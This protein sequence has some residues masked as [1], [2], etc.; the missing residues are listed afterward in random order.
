MNLLPLPRSV[1]LEGP[2][3]AATEPT[4]TIRTGLPPQ[5]YRLDIGAD[6]VRVAAA[7]DAGAFYARATL[8]QLR[9]EFGAQL[10][11]GAIE[12]WPDLPVRG[13]ML[14]IS[15][16]KV[17]TLETL[18]TLI[19]RL[20]SWK[21]NHVELYSEHTFAY[22]DHGIVWRDASPLTPEEIRELDA[23]CAARYVEL[24]PNQNT[25]G[26]FERWLRHEEYRHLALA[27]DGF[28]DAF[29]R[30]RGPTTID[31]TNPGSLDLVRALLAEL[32]PNFTARRV[33]V[34]LD[35]PWELPE[36]R[37]D[38]Y[39]AWVAQLRA[40]P[41]LD[42]YELLVWSDILAGRPERLAAVPPGVT[43]CEWGYE[44]D[45]DFDARGA[46]YAAAGVPFW[47]SPGTSSWITILGRWTNMVATTRHAIAAA[48]AHGGGGMLT[49]DWGDQGHLQHLPI[50]EPGLAYAAAVSWGYDRNADVDLAATVSSVVYADPTGELGV[51]LQELGD[52]HLAITPQ[53]PNI[54]TLVMHLYYPQIPLGHSF[55]RGVT[56]AELDDVAGRLAVVRGRL[57]R[58]TPARSDSELVLRELENAVDLVALLVRDAQLRLGGDGSLA[59]IPE[60]ARLEL[61]ADLRVVTDEHRDL[62]LTRHR[63]GGLADSHAWLENLRLAYEQG[64]ADPSWSGPRWLN[65]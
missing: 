32:L 9:A 1:A 30:R 45:S 31:P 37:V 25:L 48:L 26:H 52:L 61:A 28:T 27:P 21:I 58:A 18:L 65:G 5:G 60:A 2:F 13:V 53:F 23:F 34:G 56:T 57:A 38:D 33:H 11:S 3:V 63:P 6:G 51:A 42:G 16:D 62:W 24:V 40:L 44:A 20:A 43:I 7:D 39:L 47:V 14:D 55:T 64:F 36:S 35:E 15:R 19:D 29:G 17:P 12:D 50:S 10:P 54:S 4:V 8:A 46:A 41:E 59:S 22:R 49:T